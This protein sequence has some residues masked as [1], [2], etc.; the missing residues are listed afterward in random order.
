MKKWKRRPIEDL[1]TM[2]KLFATAEREAALMGER[3]PGAEHLVLAALQLREDSARRVFERV[4]A[5]PDA[6]R[7]ALSA[8]HADALRS[9]GVEPDEDAIDRALPEPVRSNRPMQFGASAR[10]VFPRVVELVRADRSRISG[11][12]II[13]AAAELEHGTTARTFAKM[14]VDRGELAAAARTEIDALNGDSPS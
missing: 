13:L 11:A 9:V 7:T 5:D 12:Y 6:F 3:K 10:E 4:G 1:R 2:D 14:N 8:Q